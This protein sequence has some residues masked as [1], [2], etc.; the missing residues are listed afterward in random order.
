MK[1]IGGWAAAAAAAIV[2]GGIPPKLAADSAGPRYPDGAATFQA[3]CAVCHGSKGLGTPSLAPPLTS[4]PARYVS[5]AEGRRQLAMTV[6]NGMF[7]GIDVEA[8]HYDFKMPDFSQLD[9]AALAAVLNFVVFDIAGAAQDI[10]PLA[11]EDIAAE[12]SHPEE[13]AAVREH[14]AKVL[15]ALGL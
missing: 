6:L 14:R 15:A 11:P 10:K 2:L 8:K 4:Y 7:G 3:N 1:P 13:G 12:R 9:D 5:I